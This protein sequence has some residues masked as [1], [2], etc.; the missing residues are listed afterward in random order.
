M[1]RLPWS[2]EDFHGQR[3]MK[4]ASLVAIS[5]TLLPAT[6]GV[7]FGMLAQG[8]KDSS[9]LIDVRWWP[10]L[11]VGDLPG[12]PDWHY[13]VWNDPIK[14][15][16][17]RHMLY[18]LGADCQTEFAINNDTSN[19]KFIDEGCIHEY[20]GADLHR[21]TAAKARGPR[22]LVRCSWTTLKPQ[23]VK[24]KQGYIHGNL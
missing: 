20:T 5:P 9:P 15:A 12:L 3:S 23:N 8:P 18:I 10:M 2:I 6:M 17:D 19:T 1:E 13:D 21:L 4:Y 24:Q 14:G 11:E 22:V 7:V 16:A